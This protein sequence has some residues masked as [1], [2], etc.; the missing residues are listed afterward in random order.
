MD[1][2][3]NSNGLR[4]GRYKE[5]WHEDIEMSEAQYITAEEAQEANEVRTCLQ[6]LGIRLG[7]GIID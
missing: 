7:V 4:S 3:S 6:A 2:R 1:T 5:H